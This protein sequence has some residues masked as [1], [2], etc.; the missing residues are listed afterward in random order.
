M[1]IAFLL[2]SS[3]AGHSD[4]L[5]QPFITTPSLYLCLQLSQ[6]FPETPPAPPTIPA[7][8]RGNQVDQLQIFSPLFSKSNPVLSSP[9]CSR[10]P[11]EAAPSENPTSS[12]SHGSSPIVFLDSELLQVFPGG[13]KQASSELQIF[14]LLFSK[15]PSLISQH[16]SRVPDTVSPSSLS[17]F[18]GNE[19]FL[20]ARSAFLLLLDTPRGPFHAI[21]ILKCQLPIP[22]S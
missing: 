6:A 19:Q 14:T 11:A 2:P 10:P 21:F 22:G 7:T 15:S 18:P 8:P 3:P 13:A 1:K 16:H 12:G 17:L 5:L 4:L 20:V 9:P